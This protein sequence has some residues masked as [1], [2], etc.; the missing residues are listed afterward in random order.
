MQKT[1]VF[2]TTMTSVLAVACASGGPKPD[3]ATVPPEE[4]RQA[5][6]DAG[7]PESMIVEYDEAPVL[8]NYEEVSRASRHLYPPEAAQRGETGRIQ[9]LVRVGL[10]GSVSDIRIGIPSG[11][12]ALNDAAVTVALRMRF[13]PAMRDD[14]PIVAWIPMWVQFGIVYAP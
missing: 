1:V 11:Y 5:L 12:P 2:L 6:L 3:Y 7:L 14:R 9:T 8:Q 4:I 10:D 13:S